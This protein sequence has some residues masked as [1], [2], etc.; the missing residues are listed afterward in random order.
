M[1]IVISIHKPFCEQ[2]FTGVKPL[3]FRNNL[4]KALFPGDKVFVY[5]PDGN[6]KMYAGGYSYYKEK[7]ASEEARQSSIELLPKKENCNSKQ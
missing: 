7:A 5:E 1:N 3:E 6:L 4:P 2:I